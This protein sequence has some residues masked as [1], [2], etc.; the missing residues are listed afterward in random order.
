MKLNIPRRIADKARKE[1]RKW[2]PKEMYL[3]LIGKISPCGRSVTIIDYWIPKDLIE[4]STDSQVKIPNRWRK[5]S[6][7]YAES[8]GGFVVGSIHSH[9]YTV[10]DVK[11]SPAYRL[12]PSP[13]SGDWES[14]GQEIMGIMV[15]CE[16][17]KG[18]YTTALKF[19]GPIVK[20]DTVI[21]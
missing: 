15:I 9:P 6:A 5:E 17:S 10:N 14:I 20:I 11:D 3:E 13:S 1:A 19:F 8:I 7:K 16:N 2:F 21:K 12:D 4:Y 18:G